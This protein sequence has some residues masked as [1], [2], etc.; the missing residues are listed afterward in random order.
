MDIQGQNFGIEVEMTGL[1]RS[2][3]AEIAAS[4]F[5]TR[6]QYDGSYYG[7]YSVPDTQGR[8]WKFMSDGSIDCQ[9]REGRRKVFADGSHS[10]EM[11]SPICKYEDIETVQELIRK[12]R[13]EGGAFANSS[14]GIHIHINA[15]PFDALHLRNLVNI[16]AA[17][18]DMIY[19]ALKVARGREVHYCKKIDPSFL[20]KLNQQKPTTRE[21]LKRL[22]YNGGDGSHTHYHNSRYRCLNL[23]SVFQKGTVE[24]RAFNGELH[25]GKIKA[26][27]QFCLAISAQALNQRSASPTKTQSTNEKYTFRVWLLRLGMIGK[28]FETA[29][30]HLL[31]H[32]EG[33][34]AWKDPAQAQR[35]KERLR[36]KREEAQAQRQTAP[37]ASNHPAQ[38][39]DTPNQ[40]D[41]TPD[42]TEAQEE[43]PAFVMT[44]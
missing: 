26:Y 12:L 13:D 29:R 31:D 4:Y 14:C 2:R 30:K 6:S 44:M 17:K 20:Q 24:F 36:A 11:V 23:H 16:M 15:A 1:T 18:E 33:C 43:A 21:Q 35:Q 3:A 38:A 25:A 5:G 41:E 27:I 10:V 7:T 39:E 42:Q 40:M 34:I 19:K 22:W 9:R 8:S 37:E 32:L 28:E